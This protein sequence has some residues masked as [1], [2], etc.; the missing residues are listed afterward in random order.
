ME[1]LISKWIRETLEEHE[2]AKKN[3][4]LYRMKEM[5]RLKAALHNMRDKLLKQKGF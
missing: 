1:I 4:N 3:Q 2:L 5:D